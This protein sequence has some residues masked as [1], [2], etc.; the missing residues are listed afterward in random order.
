MDCFEPEPEREVQP[1]NIGDATV[2][3]RVACE[4]TGHLRLQLH[5]DDA[6]DGILTVTAPTP[7]TTC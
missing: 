4:P 7:A 1:Q 6:H 3:F 5:A 2:G